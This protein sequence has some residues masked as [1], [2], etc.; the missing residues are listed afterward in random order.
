MKAKSSVS[1]EF[2]RLYIQPFWTLTPAFR[3]FYAYLGTLRILK[4]ANAT[5]LKM[6]PAHYL[7]E[8]SLHDELKQRH[9]DHAVSDAPLSFLPPNISFNS[10]VISA[11]TS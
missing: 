3:L 7:R 6:P 8:P 10:A 4:P 5:D 9:R 11:L 2:Q 1:S